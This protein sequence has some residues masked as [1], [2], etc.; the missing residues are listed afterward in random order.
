[1]KL[2]LTA[3]FAVFAIAWCAP[4]KADCLTRPVKEESKSDKSIIVVAP[5]SGTSE[6]LAQGY[7]PMSCASVDKIAFRDQICALQ[8]KGNIAVQK[9][10]EEVF[11]MTGARVCSAA[12]LDAPD[13][14]GE[15]LS[16]A[17]TVGSG[18]VH[19]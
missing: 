11:G 4:A 10:I 15:S 12:R 1:M 18:N 2:Y 7:K 16:S 17:S 19:E 9:R 8:A 5:A 6:Y 14:A 3:A 13:A